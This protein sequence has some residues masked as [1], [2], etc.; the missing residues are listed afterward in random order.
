MS[1]LAGIRVVSLAVNLPGPMAAQRLAALGA[2]VTK[3]EPPPGDPVATDYPALYKA[4]HRDQHVTT[5]NLKSADDNARLFQLL[6]DA[7]LLLTSSRPRSL[8][9]LGLGWDV[10]HARFPRLCYV[11]IVGYPHPDEDKP[12]HDL[13][14]QAAAG[15]LEPPLLPRL[16]IADCAGAERAVSTAIAILFAR[17]QTGE[18]RYTT[19]SLAEAAAAYADPIRHGA[20]RTGGPL[21]GALPQYRLY[22]TRSGWIALAALEKGFIETLKNK[23]DIDITTDNLSAAFL[24]RSATEW[25]HWG[26]LNDIPISAV[27]NLEE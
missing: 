19:V 10:L 13:T 20:T 16:L 3:V 2:N 15:L 4:L 26:R 27:T 17:Q 9:K 6:A 5:L 22:Q 25:E 7:D 23:L 1:P 12:G 14:Y 21:N 24:T 11:A 18:A 8:A